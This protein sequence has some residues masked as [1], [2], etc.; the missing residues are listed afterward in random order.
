MKMLMVL[1][2]AVAL[3]QRVLACD[4]CAIYSA[5]QA[6]GDIGHGTF[7]GVAE[8]FTHF[9]TVQADGV[10]V[11]NPSGQYLDSSI[12]QLFLGYNFSERVGLQFNLPV[13]YRSYKRPDGAGGNERGA[14][15]GLGDA[16][17]LLN[18][19]PVHTLRKDFTFSWGLLAGIKFPTWGTDRIKEEFSEVENPLGPPSGI[20]GHDLTL[21]SGSYDGIIGSSVY[22]RHRRVFFAASVQY[23]IRSEGDFHY[24]FANDLTWSGGPGCLVMLNDYFTLS[25][26]ALVLGEH[27]GKDTFQ[28]EKAED[29]GV[30]AVYLGPQLALTWREHLSV[31]AGVDVPVSMQNTALQTVPDYRIRA[32]LTWHF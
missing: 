11:G 5:A 31:Q 32:S 15:S 10:N 22:W 29:T 18:V 16:S 19:V 2:L 13:I 26:Q 21:G 4:L 30:T 25:L 24:Q 12:S 14:E 6:R 1:C 23:A 17:L 20:H 8:Q 7:V 9:G 3:A 28:G 27:K